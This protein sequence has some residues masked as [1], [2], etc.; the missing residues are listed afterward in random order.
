MR[1]TVKNWPGMAALA[2][3]LSL[4]P[5]VV[6]AQNLT[7][8][9]TVTLNVVTRCIVTGSSVDLGLFPSGLTQQELASVSGLGF[10]QDF[11]DTGIGYV[12]ANGNGAAPVTLAT[13]QCPV[14]VNWN[15]AIVG[16][17]ADFPST[18]FIDLVSSRAEPGDKLLTVA[19]YVSSVDG[20]TVETNGLPG[21]VVN[22]PGQ[23]FY[24]VGG[25]GNNQVQ[26][27]RGGYAVFLGDS[28]H[29]QATVKR[30]LY[31]SAGAT[32]VLNFIPSL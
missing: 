17:S 14:G 25:A 21:R 31:N 27:V 1:F 26:E 3:A 9:L 20:V 8:P 32:V 6:H 29:S 2:V 16:N 11:N 30:G 13:V 22:I 24:S 19:P 5:A 4:Q 10:V 23:N 28:A 15:L 18:N 12:A 7:A